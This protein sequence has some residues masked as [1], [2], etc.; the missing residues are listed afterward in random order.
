MNEKLAIW[1]QYG[2]ETGV[3]DKYRDAV[4]RSNRDSV[5]VLSFISIV[6]SIATI[7]FGLATKQEI[8]GLYFCLFM[9]A[10]GPEGICGKP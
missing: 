9:L 4:K 6:T 7:V 10:A 1:S 3:F 8:A 5:K 2:F